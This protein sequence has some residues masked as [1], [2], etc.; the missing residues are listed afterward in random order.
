MHH[1][2]AHDFQ[3]AGLLAD[4]AAFAATD[5]ALDVDFRRRLGEREEGRAEAYGELFL[6]ERAKEFLDGALEV[7]EADVLIDQQAFHLVEHRRVGQ[8]GVAAVHAA[9]ADDANRRLLAFHGADLYRRGMGTQQHV[10]IEIEGVMHRPGRVVA[11]DVERLEVVIVVFDL[12]AF[13]DAVADTGEELFDAFQSAGNRMQT[14]GGLATARQG[15]INALGGQ[16]GAEFGFFESR[17]ARVEHLGDAFLG[18]VDQRANFWPL[19][20]RHVAQGLH[21]LGQFA[22]LAKELNPDLF[23]GID[24]FSAFH[25]LQ[26]LGDQR[27][28]VFHVQTP[29][30]K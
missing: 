6:E 8:V 15:H 4:T 9:R 2:A 30:T 27:V 16:T 3:P 24:V 22:F 21:H 7:G 1:A 5:H 29:D 23:Q 10:G 13:G 28:Q 20:G 14:T 18:V 11:R 25:G 19:F 12:R 17:L 26:G